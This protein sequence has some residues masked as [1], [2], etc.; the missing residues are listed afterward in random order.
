MEGVGDSC[1]CWCCLWVI[2]QH[3]ALGWLVHC[4]ER[5]KVRAKY[6]IESN[7]CVDLLCSWFCGC[8]AI[9]QEAREIKARSGG[10]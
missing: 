10:Y 8:C 9:A 3:F 2:A 4:I 1:C 5:G 6:D 7:C